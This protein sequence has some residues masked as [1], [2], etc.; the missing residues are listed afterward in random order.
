MEPAPADPPRLPRSPWIPMAAAGVLW[1]IPAIY[2]SWRL[3]EKSF[4]DFYITYRYAWNLA[5]GHGFVFNPGERVFGTTAPGFGLLLALLTRSTGI[6]I[7][8]LGTLATAVA[9]VAA[10]LLALRDSGERW[11]EALAAG[12]LLLTCHYVWVQHGSEVPFTLS[13][14]LLAAALAGR[15]PLLAGLAA[16]FAVWCRPDALVGAALLG[17]IVWH[18]KRH[19]R[20][21]LPWRFGLALAV[22]VAAGLA[23]ARLWFGQFLPHT[24][25]AKRAQALVQGSS[26]KAGAA[27]WPEALD[28]IDRLYTGDHSLVLMLVGGLGLAVLWLRGGRVLRLLAANA[29][30]L[31]LAYP[32]LRVPAYTWYMIPGVIA[33]IYGAC[34]LAGEIGRRLA[35]AGGGL[36]SAAGIVGIIASGLVF[37]AVFT[38]IVVRT[39]REAARPRAFPRFTL[40]ERT[41]EW[42]RD[43]SAPG[44]EISYVEVGTL[45]Y[46][47]DR[48]V[49]DL[50]GLVSPRN[51]PFL[52]RDDFLGAFRE[53]PTMFLIHHEKLAS[54]TGPIVRHRWFRRRWDEVHREAM[55]SPGEA[56]VVYRRNGVPY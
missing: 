30:A 39:A 33:A 9:L 23:A 50:V 51:L 1:L 18:E 11:P 37:A 47:S 12:S 38:P 28:Q 24:L 52:L 27:F 55:R 7:P 41:G 2:A 21:R 16:G 54:F 15:H 8:W 53:H 5:A 46:F 42:I 31:A 35:G 56:L 26:W 6:S 4:D 34:F 19:E 17:L 25:E 48:P 43:C 36:R 10:A 49:Q 40:Y 45:A 14:L 22:V 44:D 20:R 13:L 32:L 3:G 29:A